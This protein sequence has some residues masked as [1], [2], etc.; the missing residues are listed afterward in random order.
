MKI[1]LLEKA[2]AAV[3]IDHVGYQEFEDDGPGLWVYG[4]SDQTLVTR[5]AGNGYGPRL[6]IWNPWDDDGDAFRLAVHE[7]VMYGLRHGL[8]YAGRH[9]LDRA[10]QP[11]TPLER[12]AWLREHIVREVVARNNQNGLYWQNTNTGETK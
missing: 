9:V 1:E 12:L 11:L 5:P 3:G 2:A 4:Y 7:G 10:V 8:M 6:W